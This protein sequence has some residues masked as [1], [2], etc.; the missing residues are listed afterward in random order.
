MWW[1]NHQDECS[2]T[3]FAVTD[4]WTGE[5]YGCMGLDMDVH[6]RMGEIG[7]R[8]DPHYWNQ[9]I[10]AEAAKSIIRFGFDVQQLHK[11]NGRFFAYNAASGRVME[12]AGMEREGL[13]KK[14]VWKI[15]RFEDIVLYG[16]VNSKHGRAGEGVDE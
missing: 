5:L 13:Q 14:H 8:I 7:Y 6:S 4:K 16:I 12:K 11:I 2:E 10:A 1:I 9:G 15:D 3:N